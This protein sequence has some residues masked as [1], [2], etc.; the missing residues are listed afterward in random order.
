[1]DQVS[2]LILAT[3]EILATHSAVASGSYLF[4]LSWYKERL[5]DHL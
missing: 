5:Y 4:P 1:M 2:L 3:M